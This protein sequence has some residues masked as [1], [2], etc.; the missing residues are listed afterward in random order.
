MGL[1]SPLATVFLFA[2][3]YLFIKAN[4]SALS[5]PFAVM[6]VFV[7][8]GIVVTAFSTGLK[9][10][11]WTNPANYDVIAPVLISGTLLSPPAWRWWLSGAAVVGV[12]FSGSEIALGAAAVILVIV[13]IRKDTSKRL[14]VPFA[15]LALCILV[16]S[17]FGVT[18]K[19]WIKN[20]VQAAL[21]E[22]VQAAFS[23]G[24]AKK[25]DYL[26]TGNRLYGNWNI[27]PV[28]LL[29]HGVNIRQLTEDTPHNQVLI[30]VDQIGIIGAA[31]WLT[32]SVIRLRKTRE[33]YL[34]GAVAVIGMVD[35]FFWTFGA[36]W[37][38]AL[39]AVMPQGLIFK[40]GDAVPRTS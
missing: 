36:T 34:W 5:V 4:P 26:I 27:R 39:L 7:T 32:A 23:G 20:D 15:A 19:L 8:I 30:M 17:P 13:L 38:W 3:V 24:D 14:I 12:F 35:H 21:G 22:R 6:V 33:W 11:G 2:S 28:T 16:A 37:W 40:R 25:L 18:Q 29:G 31:A 1:V 9:N 10:G